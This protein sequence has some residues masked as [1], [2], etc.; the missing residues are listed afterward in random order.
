MSN[1]AGDTTFKIRN[2]KLYVLIITSSTKDNVKLTNKLNEGFERS[3]YWHNYKTKIESKEVD[4]NLTRFYLDASFERVKRLFFLAFYNTDNCN[5]EIE[6]NGPR[7][8]FFQRVNI[9]NYNV[10]I[11]GRN[12]CNQPIN[13]QIKKFDEIRKVATG[14]ENDYTTGY[15]MDYQYFKNHYQVIAVDLRK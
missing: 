11:D 13:D 4:D 14:Q 3:V 7:K 12:F 1:I 8:Y 2:T 10:L 5:E 9:T 15:L 6:R